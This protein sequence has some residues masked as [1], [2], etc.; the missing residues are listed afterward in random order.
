[1]N[2]PFLDRL[3]PLAAGVAV[4]LLASCGSGSGTG[5]ATTVRVIDAA[6][7]SPTNFDAFQ[8]G[9]K[10]ATDLS[11][12]QVSTFQ[13]LNSGTASVQIDPTGTTT[14]SY[15]A[16]FAAS[17]GTQYSVVVVEG[18]AGLTA[19]NVAQ[20][21]STV[22]S[23]QARLDMVNADPGQSSLDFYVTGPTG[24]LPAAASVSS[25]AYAGDGQSATP[26][27]LL[28][29][30]G[31][32][33]IRAVVHGDATLAVVFDSGPVTLTPASALLLLAVPAGGSASGFS[34]LAVPD[35]GA[36]YTIG[37]QRV[38]VRFGNFAPG[39]GTV[40]TFVVPAGSA[41]MSSNQFSST[42]AVDAV[43]PYLNEL[44]GANRATFAYTGTT[45][46]VLGAPLVLVAGQPV[47]VFAT[48]VTQQ[49]AT[50]GLQVLV[51]A[52]DLA[53]APSGNA[54]LRVVA[55]APDFGAADVVLLDTSGATPVIK[56]RLAVNLSYGA[57]ASYLALPAG[58]YTIALVPTGADQP[59]LPA[60]G[61]AQTLA[62]GKVYTLVAA[63]CRY[64][65]SG[66]CLFSTSSITFYLLQDR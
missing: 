3:L 41:P 53:P 45:V 24:V 32:Y 30:S 59:L 10:I 27:S 50:S 33:R 52:D 42:L 46:E 14:V 65:A 66:G 15:T 51:L 64:P 19:V 2:L 34:L 44:P 58:A 29:N 20:S 31:D 28:V 5:G 40:D 57:A 11:F 61:T 16:S 43:T 63:G 49:G 18:T 8:G 17:G 48:G 26:A 39:L 25:V 22:P 21:T 7:Q 38:P 47:S 6:Y 56:R 12:G 36:P 9:T 62:A 23:G 54:S 35:S 37:D 1:M 13:S 55:L 4:F 60:A